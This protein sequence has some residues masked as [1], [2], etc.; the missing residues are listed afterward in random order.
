MVLETLRLLFSRDLGKLKQEIGLYHDEQTIW[1]FEKG[2]A[3]SAGNL[4]LHLVGNLKTY[5]GQELGGI[6]YTRNRDLEFALKNIPRAELIRMA[7]E[8]ALAVDQAS[9]VLTEND[10]QAEYPL[11]VFD[12]KTSTGY[13]LIH[14][15]TH[16]TYH[17][18][19]I[20]YHRR[21]LDA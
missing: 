19:Q 20:N 11:L 14:L 16:L 5:I 10:L 12:A 1:H 6:D 21:L 17:L 9:V 15:A 7:E 2:I 4:G 18:G 13:F 3:N 8:T